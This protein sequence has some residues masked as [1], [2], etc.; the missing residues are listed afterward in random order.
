MSFIGYG[1]AFHE[2]RTSRNLSLEAASANIVTKSF[3]SKF[4]RGDTSI[5][6]ENLLPLLERI[7]VS[8]TEYLLQANNMSWGKDDVL[9]SHLV[10][11]INSRDSYQLQRMVE[12][13]QEVVKTSADPYDQLDLIAIKA[14]RFYVTKEPVTPEEVQRV[15]DYLFGIDDWLYY[16]LNLLS[17]SVGI[18]PLELLTRYAKTI[19]K[20]VEHFLRA[21]LNEQ[22][23]SEIAENVMIRLLQAHYLDA[24]D[25]MLIELSNSPLMSGYTHANLAYR[26]LSAIHR[27]LSGDQAGGIADFKEYLHVLEWLQLGDQSTQMIGIW[28]NL[29]KSTEI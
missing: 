1:P 18:L 26:Y 10:D 9:F 16:D 17:L 13:Q 19:F 6:I 21:N 28:R 3:L 5:S 23:V 7:N 11:Y 2:L 29:T 4:E 8:A 24:A 27:Y 14:A 15:S 20:S 25:A 22:L 12:K